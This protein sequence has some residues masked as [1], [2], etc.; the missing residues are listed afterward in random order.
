M[1]YFEINNKLKEK[2]NNPEYNDRIINKINYGV[3]WS[4]AS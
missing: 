1:F 4:G 2:K 3:T